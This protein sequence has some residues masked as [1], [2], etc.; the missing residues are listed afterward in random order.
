LT[1]QG[2]TTVSPTRGLT[3]RLQ[4]DLAPGAVAPGDWPAFR[5]AV[6]AVRRAMQQPVVLVDEG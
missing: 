1:L 4:L 2:E 3:R 6:A 5:D